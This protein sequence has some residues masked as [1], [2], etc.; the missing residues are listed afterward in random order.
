MAVTVV[1]TG[2]EYVELRSRSREAG[3]TAPQY[4]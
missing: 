1:L 3:T 2:E 4:N